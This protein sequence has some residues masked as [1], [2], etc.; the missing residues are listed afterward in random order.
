M[1]MK[2]GG[3]YNPP[4]KHKKGRILPHDPPL[5]LGH[6]VDTRRLQRRR[7]STHAAHNNNIDWFRHA[8]I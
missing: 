2:K 1:P 3:S 4:R 5:K 6:I 8:S 7:R